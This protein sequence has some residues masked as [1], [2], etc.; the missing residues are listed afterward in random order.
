MVEFKKGMIDKQQ[1]GNILSVFKK[2]DQN[3]KDALTWE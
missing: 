2:F 1:Q 3:G